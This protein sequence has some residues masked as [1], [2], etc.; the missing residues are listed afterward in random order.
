MSAT[1]PAPTRFIGSASPTPI[2]SVRSEGEAGAAGADPLVG[3]GELA[4]DDRG[5]TVEAHGVLLYSSC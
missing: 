2:A 3:V 4:D 5:T 1:N